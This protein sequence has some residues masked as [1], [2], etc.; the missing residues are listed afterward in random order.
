MR[1]STLFLDSASLD[2]KT[3]LHTLLMATYLHCA[4]W[5]ERKG[6]PIY[7]LLPSERGDLGSQRSCW[8]YSRGCPGSLSFCSRM[9]SL[10]LL[11]LWSPCLL[12]GRVI[13]GDWRSGSVVRE[14]VLCLQ[15]T[16]IWFPRDHIKQLK[17][18][19]IPAP[20]TLYLCPLRA[21]GL[22]YTY[23]GRHT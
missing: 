12:G 11:S 4:K 5:P 10:P 15:K 21:S 22:I 6:V 23:L 20:R 1:I 17:L 2:P 16:H 7:S 13:L 8:L 14:P 9:I 3:D 18:L 19:L